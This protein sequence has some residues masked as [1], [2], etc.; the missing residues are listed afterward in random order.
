MKQFKLFRKVVT[1]TVEEDLPEVGVSYHHKDRDHFDMIDHVIP[2][3]VENGEVCY[4]KF[5]KPQ[6]AK[7]VENEVC[8][9][10]EFN[11][12]FRRGR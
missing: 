12:W 6:Y 8:A 9:V 11:K 2:Q 3:W 10:A 7:R 1:V 5:Y 4:A